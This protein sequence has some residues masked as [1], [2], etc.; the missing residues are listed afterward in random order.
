MRGQQGRIHSEGAEPQ[1]VCEEDLGHACNEVRL[2]TFGQTGV[3]FSD[4]GD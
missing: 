4:V 2:R 1:I 3:S